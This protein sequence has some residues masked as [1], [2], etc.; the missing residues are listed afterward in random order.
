MIVLG[1]SLRY[2]T[3]ITLTVF[4]CSE[5]SG[6]FCKIKKIFTINPNFAQ[7]TIGKFGINI[8]ICHSR[9]SFIVVEYILSWVWTVNGHV[10]RNGVSCVC[11]V[12]EAVNTIKSIG[13]VRNLQGKPKKIWCKTIG[14]S[15]KTIISFDKLY[16]IWWKSS[17]N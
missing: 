5:F 15:Y 3:W 6:L 1:T 14:V 11:C 10:I 12:V 2:I 8:R 9:K 16:F 13:G 4:Q 17:S 7:I